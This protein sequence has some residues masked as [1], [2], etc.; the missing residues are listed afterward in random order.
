MHNI[1]AAAAA[2]SNAQR[3]RGDANVASVAKESL[4]EA[5]YTSPRR[6][7]KWRRASTLLTFQGA[8]GDTAPSNFTDHLSSK[9]A[10]LQHVLDDQLEEVMTLAMR[11]VDEEDAA[12]LYRCTKLAESSPLLQEA[13][14]RRRTAIERAMR[15]QLARSWGRLRHTMSETAEDLSEGDLFIHRSALAE[16]AHAQEGVLT[17]ARRAHSVEERHWQLDKAAAIREAL[18]LQRIE[19]MG[20]HEAANA[21]LLEEMQTKL[22]EAAMKMEA[23][24]QAAQAEIDAMREKLR[25]AE[26][27]AVRQREAHDELARKLK[28]SPAC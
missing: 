27:R 6:A 17:N 26:E 28:D 4:R 22:R 16:R 5:G 18:R 20:E 7:K 3:R 10:A 1:A 21:A 11:V 14:D 13:A 2:A 19:L 8:H 25:L 23:V 12:F 15:D 9:T 24:Q